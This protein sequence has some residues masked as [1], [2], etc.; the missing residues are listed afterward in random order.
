[1]DKVVET[2]VCIVGAGPGGSA[3]S[4]ILSKHKINHVLIDKESFPRDKTCGDGLILN[5]F[6]ALRLIDEKLF[7]KFL[8]HPKF[9]SSNN[10][11]FHV[12]NS[13]TIN[14]SYKGN[15]QHAPIFY[16]KRIDFDQFLFENT[17]SKYSTT[18]VGSKV[19]KIEEHDDFVTVGLKDGTQIKSKF[20][21]GAD[22]INS[23]VSKKLGCNKVDQ[24]RSSIFV[25]AYFKNVKTLANN[26]AEIRLIYKEMPLFFYVF[27]LANNEVNVSIGGV[28]SDILKHKINLKQVVD[29]VM[30]NHSKVAHKFKEAEQISEWRGHGIPS[31]FGHL[32][33]YGKRFVLVG[34][35][36][37]L[38]NA[39]YK[40]GVGSAMMSGYIAANKINEAC[41]ENKLDKDKFAEYEQELKLELG[42][43][44]KYSKVTYKISRKKV[45]FSFFVKL[46]KPLIERKINQI[47]HK[48]TY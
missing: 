12:S 3:T 36:A 2:D 17:K 8:K 37:G 26:Q 1:M 48:K 7:Q 27:P 47:I 41:I 24:T 30:K 33:I 5:T 32:N 13:N 46:F 39:F 21:V 35:A 18:L 11:K 34:D 6:K 29:E 15:Q 14:I 10:G 25:S 20:I 38:A 42:K 23:L 28:H 44:F 9:I 19:S 45:M 4:M 43:L 22:G 31:N 40:E 16:G